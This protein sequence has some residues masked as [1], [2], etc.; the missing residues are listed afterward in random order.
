MNGGID[1]L[2]KLIN[3]TDHTYKTPLSM[4][5]NIQEVMNKCIGQMPIRI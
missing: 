3:W 4:I 1:N 5:E 2:M